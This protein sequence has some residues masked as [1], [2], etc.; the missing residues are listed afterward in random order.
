MSPK[1]TVTVAHANP[2]GA[3]APLQP[4]A[5]PKYLQ[6]TYW[7]AYLHPNAVRVF[8][9]Q[10][11]VNLILWGNFSRLRDAALQEMGEVID[12]KVLQVATWST[13]PLSLIHISE[14]TR[15]Y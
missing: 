1:E 2:S 15:P 9:R 6:D 5:I 13:L 14:P 3:G 12:G 4:I 7:W 10:W 8:E 11:L